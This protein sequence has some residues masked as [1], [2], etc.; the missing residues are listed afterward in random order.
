M[1]SSPSRRLSHPLTSR[2]PDGFDPVRAMWDDGYG[3]DRDADFGPRW[4]WPASGGSFSRSPRFHTGSME[5]TNTGLYLFPPING[6][7]RRPLPSTRI[8]TY[9]N[10]AFTVLTNRSRS[11][12]GHSPG[13]SAEQVPP[14]D[15]D[16]PGMHLQLM[17]VVRDA[18]ASAPGTDFGGALEDLA[19]YV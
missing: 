9:G 8:P 13:G 14:P 6:N 7:A 10:A 3:L 18:I 5:G 19:A 16:T 4:Y 2:R 15:D 1:V 11:S 17:W 12:Q